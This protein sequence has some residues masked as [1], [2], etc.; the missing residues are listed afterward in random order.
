MPRFPSPASRRGAAALALTALLATTTLAFPQTAT[1]ATG[2]HASSPAAKVKEWGRKLFKSPKLTQAERN[3]KIFSV[4]GRVGTWEDVLLEDAVKE[5]AKARSGTYRLIVKVAS[6]AYGRYRKTNIVME[7]SRL[8]V[9]IYQEPVDAYSEDAIRPQISD[10]PL[11]YGDERNA[12]MIRGYFG[13]A[14][15]WTPIQMFRES[16]APR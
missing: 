8:G 6:S 3:R 15:D 9:R 2:S 7:R 4:G 1:A 5:V 14:S 13:T 10:L 12:R 11:L 16:N